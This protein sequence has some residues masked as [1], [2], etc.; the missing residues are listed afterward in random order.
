VAGD[1]SAVIAGMRSELRRLEP[2]VLIDQVETMSQRIE[3]SVAPR[4]LNLILFALFAVLALVLAAVGLYGVVAYS[5][6]Q[7]TQEFGIRMA[8]GALPLDV[9]N[10]VL[11]QGLRLAL[12]GVAIGIAVALA[13]TRLIADLLFG[14]EPSD[15]VTLAGVSLLLTIVALLACGLPAYRATR[16]APTVALRWE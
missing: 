10:L 8:I 3:D 15:P 12:T 11:G 2:G 9:L 6:S 16:I 5:V 14:V 13:V 1:P 7:R 4:R